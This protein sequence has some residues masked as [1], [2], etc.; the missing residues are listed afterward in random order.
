ME[1]HSLLAASKASRHT[2]C[3]SRRA[4]WPI[5]S[6]PGGGTG[7][8]QPLHCGARLDSPN[9]PI[10]PAGPGATIGPIP[11][12]TWATGPIDPPAVSLARRDMTAWPGVGFAGKAQVGEG[13]GWPTPCPAGK[14]IDGLATGE[15]DHRGSEARRELTQT[16]SS[17]HW[18]RRGRRT[19][20]SGATAGRRRA[21]GERP[22]IPSS[23][24]RLG[25]VRAAIA[26]PG[27]SSC[28]T[29][30]DPVKCA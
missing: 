17:W 12:V 25:K 24:G 6:P 14:S 26:G 13:W 28:V 18:A 3:R 20:V 4:P 5:E 1:R 22:P 11:T 30:L 15:R 29:L 10:P 2:R 8:R 9:R 19:V 23:G 16:P 21:N 27:H 7:D